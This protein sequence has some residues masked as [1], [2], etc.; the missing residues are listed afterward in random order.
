MIGSDDYNNP[1][2][3]KKEILEK[4]KK[5]KIVIVLPY[6][7]NIHDVISSSSIVCLPT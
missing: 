3:I 2:L 1:H 5:N 4:A 7:S 6:R